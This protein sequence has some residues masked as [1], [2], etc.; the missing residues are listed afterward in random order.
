[1]YS[2]LACLA[3]AALGI[4]WAKLHKDSRVWSYAVAAMFGLFALA[5]VYV[6]VFIVG[7]CSLLLVFFICLFK[8][9]KEGKDADAH[10]SIKLNSYVRKY[11]SKD[12]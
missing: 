5:Q 4:V 9:Y 2:F 10:N 8:N 1:M 12:E 3:V 11:T 7:V 6:I